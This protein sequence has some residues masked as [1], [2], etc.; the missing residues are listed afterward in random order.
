M[1]AD[2]SRSQLIRPPPPRRRRRPRPRTPCG[3]KIAGR[4]CPQSSRVSGPTARIWASVRV[5][6]TIVSRVSS[7]QGSPGATVATSTAWGG[8][9][10]G[11]SRWTATPV[12][13]AGPGTGSVQA[14]KSS[15]LTGPASTAAA[16][17][18]S[19][20]TQVRPP[21]RQASPR[22]PTG[23]RGRAGSGRPARPPPG[24]PARR[25]GARAPRRSA[26]RRR[27][28]VRPAAATSTPPSGRR[29]AGSTGRRWRPGRRHWTGG[30]GGGPAA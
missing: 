24:R 2:S 26:R 11:E 13:A 30:S 29:D 8:W 17:S 10:P 7:D 9:A 3:R 20:S 28:P 15:P 5:W 21:A 12:V 22:P 25:R 4:E 27:G 19:E 6:V 16:R 1:A 18:V 23:R 14:S